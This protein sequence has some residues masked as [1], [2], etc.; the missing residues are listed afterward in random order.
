MFAFIV[1]ASVSSGAAAASEAVAFL[2]RKMHA[3]QG[4]MAIRRERQKREQKRQS[5]IRRMSGK[6]S[7]SPRDSDVSNLERPPPNATSTEPPK[8]PKTDSS[9]TAF[10]LGVVFI[11]LGTY[12]K[13]TLLCFITHKN[14]IMWGYP[15]PGKTILGTMFE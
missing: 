10:H 5:Q 12:Q 2:S 3:I 13:F 11:L 8:P 15:D 9:M 4:A 14:V 7:A 1:A 6:T